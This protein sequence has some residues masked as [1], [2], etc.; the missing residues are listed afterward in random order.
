[1]H[2]LCGQAGVCRWPRQFAHPSDEGVDVMALAILDP[3]NGSIDAASGFVTAARPASLDG[4]TFGIMAN[5]LGDSEIMFDALYAK[6]AEADGVSDVVKVV[7]ASVAVPLPRGVG[8][9]HRLGHRGG[10]RLGGCGS[11]STAPC[12]MPWTRA[13]GI[14]AVCIVHTALVPAVRAMARLVGCPDYPSSR[15]TT[16]TT[17]RGYGRRRR[18]W[19]WPLR[20]PCRSGTPDPAL[21]TLGAP[22][23]LRHGRG[24]ARGLFRARVDRRPAGGPR[25][26]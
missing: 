12:A 10:D 4:Q 13:A 1:L 16:P 23:H 9:V 17:R 14:P 6:L 19:P 2:V 15:S 26:R 24:G 5:G 11:C 22:P 8:S 21:V 7:K 20:L 25:H 18:R 3:T